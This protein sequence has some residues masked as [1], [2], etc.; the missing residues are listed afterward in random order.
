MK[1]LQ[2]AALIALFAIISSL[3]SLA[4]LKL[5][6]VMDK[7]PDPYISNWPNK[8][9][10]LIATII[11]TGKNSVDVKFDC[12]IT[13]DGILQANTEPGKMRTISVPPGASQYFAET[14]MPMSAM[15]ISG[16]ADKIA[17]QTGML[18]AGDYEFCATLIDPN[19]SAL[20]SQ[21][22]CKFF[23]MTSYQCPVLLQ[24]LNESTLS[25]LN[26]PTFRWAAVSPKPSYTVT[27]RVCVFE[28]LKGQ[29]PAIA[30]QAN[31]PILDRTTTN[32]FLIWPSDIENPIIYSPQN[33]LYVWSVQAL[34]D[35]GNPICETGKGW[36]EPLTFFSCCVPDTSGNDGLTDSGILLQ[37]PENG[38]VIDPDTHINFIW[39]YKKGTTQ[40]AGS[41]LHFSLYEIGAGQSASDALKNRPLWDVASITGTKYQYPANAPKLEAG[42]Q[43]A[44]TIS[45]G[46]RTSAPFGFTLS[47]SSVSG[48]GKDTVPKDSTRSANRIYVQGPKITL[49]FPDNNSEIDLSQK[50]S[51]KWTA[52]DKA[53]S[54]SIKIVEIIDDQTPEIAMK[55][56][57]P[58]Y[59]NL[60]IPTNSIDPYFGINQQGVKVYAW[61]VSSGGSNS[62]IFTFNYSS[63]NFNNSNILT[64]NLISPTE[65]NPF[66][67]KHQEFQF[68]ASNTNDIESYTIKIYEIDRKNQSL[69]L[70]TSKTF[71]IAKGIKGQTWYYPPDAP[72]MDTAKLYA[73]IVDAVGNSKML[74]GSSPVESF[75]ACC[76]GPIGPQPC[77]CTLIAIGINP[78]TVT[79]C[80]GQPLPNFSYNFSGPCTG[81]IVYTWS[82]TFTPTT[83]G[84]YPYTCTVSNGNVSC[85][86]PVT[87]IVVPPN[88]PLN[89]EVCSPTGDYTQ[90][91][92]VKAFKLKFTGS[93]GCSHIPNTYFPAS[94]TITWYI[95]K[96]VVTPSLPTTASS[97]TFTNSC[98]D[99]TTGT[100]PALGVWYTFG[101]GSNFTDA[102]GSSSLTSLEFTSG[103]QMYYV[104]C[105]VTFPSG[106]FN[107]MNSGFVNNYY[108]FKVFPNTSLINAT[109]T[110][111]RPTCGSNG[112]INITNVTGAAPPFTFSLNNGTYT[113]VAGY[114]HLYSNLP[115]SASYTVYIK[116]ANGCLKS[117]KGPFNLDGPVKPN[118]ISIP[119][120][121]HIIPCN[122]NLKL[123]STTNYSANP[124]TYQWM[125]CSS[126]GTCNAIASCNLTN[127]PSSSYTNFG[128]ATSSNISNIITSSGCYRVKV[129]DA[130]GGCNISDPW[131]V[132]NSNNIVYPVISGPSNICDTTAITLTSTGTSLTW[133][134]NGV[135]VPGG[136]TSSITE[137]PPNGPG[138]YTVTTTNGACNTTSTFT[139]T[140]YPC[141][142]CSC[143]YSITNSTSTASYIGLNSSGV[144]IYSIT[145][146]INNMAGCPGYIQ[147]IAPSSSSATL[148]TPAATYFVPIGN[149]NFTF[150]FT[151]SITANSMLSF[152]TQYTPLSGPIS[153]PPCKHQI[154]ADVIAMMPPAPTP[155][156]LPN[157][158]DWNSRATPVPGISIIIKRNGSEI[159]QPTTNDGNGNYTFNV[160]S[161]SGIG[162]CDIMFTA[163]EEALAAL[164]AAKGD[165]VSA[166][167]KIEMTTASGSEGGVLNFESIK[168]GA[169]NSN[170]KDSNVFYIN[171]IPKKG[172][173]IT[174]SQFGTTKMTIGG[175]EVYT[176]ALF[177]NVEVTEKSAYI[178][179]VL[180]VT[181]PLRKR[182]YIRSSIIGINSGSDAYKITMISPT[183]KKPQKSLTPTFSWTA[184]SDPKDV[185][186]HLRLVKVNT[187]QYMD[188]A[189][190]L[191]ENAPIWD[192]TDIAETSIALTGAAL[193]AGEVYV[194]DIN[195]NKKGTKPDNTKYSTGYIG[196]DASQNPRTKTDNSQYPGAYSVIIA[197]DMDTLSFAC[198]D[199]YFACRM[200][201]GG[202]VRFS[203]SDCE[204]LPALATQGTINQTKDIAHVPGFNGTSRSAPIPGLNIIVKRHPGGIII[205]PSTNDGNGNYTFNVV[206][207]GAFKS[208]L[209]R[210]DI[211]LTA[212]EE[213]LAALKAAKGNG[214]SAEYKIEMTTASGSEGGVLN[215]ESIKPG[216][217]SSSDKDSNVFYI[218]WIPKKGNQITDTY[219]SLTKMTIGGKEVYAKA[220]FTNVEVT[221]K[222]SVIHVVL[223]VTPPQ[224]ANTDGQPSRKDSLPIDSLKYFA[225]PRMRLPDP[226][227]GKTTDIGAI[228]G[229]VLQKG[230]EEGLTIGGNSQTS[231]IIPHTTVVLRAHIELGRPDKPYADCTCSG[232]Y[233]CICSGIIIRVKDGS[234][235][236]YDALAKT[237]IPKDI[238]SFN[239]QGDVLKLI[240]K[241]KFILKEYKINQKYDIPFDKE[242]ANALGYE[243]MTVL[244]GRYEIVNGNSLSYKFKNGKE[245][246]GIIWDK[247]S[248]GKKDS[249]TQVHIWSGPKDSTIPVQV[250]Y[251]GQIEKNPPKDSTHS[252]F[253]PKIETVAAIGNPND[254]NI[255]WKPSVQ[256][257]VTGRPTLNNQQTTTATNKSTCDCGRWK[258]NQIL[259]TDITHHGAPSK[260]LVCGDEFNPT[261]TYSNVNIVFPEYICNPS[262]C[263]STY[264][265]IISGP[266][267]T[268]TGN[269]NSV[270]AANFTAQGYYTVSMYVYCGNKKCDSCKI[271]VNNTIKPPCPKLKVSHYSVKCHNLIN[272]NNYDF[273]VTIDNNEPT[274]GT[275]SLS[276]M[277]SSLTI[278]SYTP[279]SANPFTST[280]ID[281]NITGYGTS[282]CIKV[283]FSINH[284]ICDT[285]ICFQLPLCG[286]IQKESDKTGQKPTLACTCGEWKTN[287]VKY[288][289]LQGQSS[290]PNLAES[291]NDSISCN[292]TITLWPNT[293]YTFSP[294]S[295]TCNPEIS[296][297]A[298]TYQWT[299]G[300]YQ[301]AATTTAASP[302]Y[303]FS[304]APGTH[305]VNITPFCADNNC[306]PCVITVNAVE[307]QFYI[308]KF[309]G[310][311]KI[312]YIDGTGQHG[313]IAATVDQGSGIPWCY[314]N[315]SNNFILTNATGTSV[316]TG[317]SNTSAIV[318]IYANGNYAAKLCDQLTLG[319]YS[320]WYLPSI[321]ELMLLYAQRNIIGGFSGSYWSS[322][323][324]DLSDAWQKDFNSATPSS[325]IV[326]D[327]YYFKVR[328]IRSF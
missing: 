238:Q 319:G 280:V 140:G 152:V 173:H 59:E 159:I 64:I 266:Q 184:A 141:N 284:N 180:N 211:I 81:P 12:K 226:N 236:T 312:F 94:T 316:G 231:T 147:M 154:S 78:L 181:P 200:D 307:P 240:F 45:Y 250:P 11:N 325:F 75:G 235:R 261:I 310:G 150:Y 91:C 93:T 98:F 151:S 4:Q 209:G 67:D 22:V 84:S 171:W 61:Q 290:T 248:D 303:V 129:M 142:N 62:E 73:W 188:P 242:T 111:T 258:T 269:T 18:Q 234:D 120:L 88:S 189:N 192:K 201:G 133:S 232:D 256:N 276:S 264:N 5:N 304:F 175:K 274:A 305:T 241:D 262:T 273:K 283:S 126:C 309:Y 199:C 176:K 163:T 260:A 168:P 162:N 24:P 43:Y 137:Y 125:I 153:G 317:Q 107:C 74:I 101:N 220:L 96:S 215:F 104:S 56:N 196:G 69:L 39:D 118:I 102:P 311:G 230:R 186:Y 20:L 139:V 66:K 134:R 100:S 245:I 10:T 178:H 167:Y 42:K 65:A 291:T 224:V 229:S 136:N 70:D 26:R 92:S 68:R 198:A 95:Q 233:D 113:T 279:T 130:N 277:S 105:K 9:G 122:G 253:I 49:L 110:V 115:A 50:Q 40:P 30:I 295:F 161:H 207:P 203:L 57:K 244:A 44:W 46:S 213:A 52:L 119:P 89:V 313:L 106:T 174:D 15:K 267:G 87:L 179:V 177:T 23:T 146:Y 132:S 239:I 195:A 165:G 324:A 222:S 128:T 156:P 323:E 99:P 287:K 187:D 282:I 90:C 121:T 318:A 208:D 54:Y 47:K 76:I 82:P 190:A 259:F 216:V 278:N 286:T 218:N 297:C 302:N 145:V 1:T 299:G 219:P 7:H 149:S 114:S 143:S 83:V 97:Y 320:D 294:P 6:L 112:S 170:D 206:Q 301:G 38:A 288:K 237:G 148:V 268:Q 77:M 292:G 158:N 197:G 193:K 155:T 293:Y 227:N 172:L 33:T 31:F 55:Q 21:E 14:L 296:A 169:G 308:G 117:F 32:T 109:V 3:P 160:D 51:F 85:T 263:S 135:P 164:K 79:A 265:W 321:D 298:L 275:I 36:A 182:Q 281:G 214:I 221:E 255:T 60:R 223:N 58:V 228:R 315:S 48:S 257:A 202:C 16:N 53:E 254:S 285:I 71:Y 212:T 27:Y 138:V 322:T 194:W 272:S 246:P 157:P 247:G 127:C 326:K 13:R 210:L 29:T 131:Y 314:Y 34:D 300:M 35:Q 28:V 252:E 183:H 205:Q 185:L 166:E 271:Y 25:K 123:M 270:T 86:L 80:I 217:G 116:D 19:T 72:P 2:R 124:V 249:T 306:T 327:F 8:R 243:S 108:T 289:Y 17:I 41:I 251:S 328:A 63:D 37:Q 103:S 191:K 144:P 204:C 225:V